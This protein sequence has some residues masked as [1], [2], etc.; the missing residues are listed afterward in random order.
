MEQNKSKHKIDFEVLEVIG[1]HF[2]EEGDVIV[3]VIDLAPEVQAAVVQVYPPGTIERKSRGEELNLAISDIRA[4]IIEISSTARDDYRKNV[5]FSRM[6][7][8]REPLFLSQ[9]KP[10]KENMTSNVPCR[11]AI[12]GLPPISINM[13]DEEVLNYFKQ[14]FLNL[15]VNSMERVMIDVA[16]YALPFAISVVYPKERVLI[17]KDT[18]IS[19]IIPVGM[20]G[21]KVGF[22]LHPQI[23]E[24]LELLLLQE[25]SPDK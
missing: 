8:I 20:V 18:F 19:F 15:S 10:T 7:D 22:D 14:K 6:S 4:A 1:G 16:G 13:R 25:S 21:E 24:D 17:G 5:V 9:T 2:S 23:P 12:I 3:G 11:L